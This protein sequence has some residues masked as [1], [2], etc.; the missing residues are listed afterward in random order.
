MGLTLPTLSEEQLQQLNQAAARHRS[1]INASSTCGCFRCLSVFGPA[2][3]RKW[4]QHDATALCP[5]CD[6]DAV[7]GDA[8]CPGLNRKFLEVMHRRWFEKK[9][10]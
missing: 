1:L 3:I 5:R 6:A 9:A 8:S 7:I 10:G 4:I 2:E